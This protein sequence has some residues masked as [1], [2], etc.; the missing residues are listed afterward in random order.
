MTIIADG[1]LNNN[2]IRELQEAV[3]GLQEGGPGGSGFSGEGTAIT[4]LLPLGEV[5]D[6]LSAVGITGLYSPTA[7]EEDNTAEAWIGIWVD[8]DVA[9]L[10]VGYGDNAN[11]VAAEV[12]STKATLTVRPVSGQSVAAPA[13]VVKND[14]GGDRFIVRPDGL[15]VIVLPTSDPAVDGALWRSG[16]DVKVS[17]G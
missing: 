7:P 3:V 8:E 10:W 9:Y 14:M 15:V 4:A 11:G 2:N 17:T 13:F 12:R 5:T 1:G 6:N 16:N